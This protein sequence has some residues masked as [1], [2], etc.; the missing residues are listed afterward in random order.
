MKDDNLDFDINLLIGV[1]IIFKKLFGA[2]R[3][4]RGNLRNLYRLRIEL[5]KGHN[6]Y[7]SKLNHIRYEKF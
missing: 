3:S 2:N 1:M 7:S 6:V 4:L 5:S